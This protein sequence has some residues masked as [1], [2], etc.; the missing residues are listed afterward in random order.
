M[1]RYYFDQRPIVENAQMVRVSTFVRDHLRQFKKVYTEYFGN[2]PDLS[3]SNH[4][5]LFLDCV[6]GRAKLSLSQTINGTIETSEPNP[7]KLM[8]TNSNLGKGF[9]FWFVCNNCCRKARILYVPPSSTTFL[10][11]ICHMLRYQGKRK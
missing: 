8:I 7:I 1:F 6:N 5:S 3:N 4:I 2:P 11:R 10:C 9:V